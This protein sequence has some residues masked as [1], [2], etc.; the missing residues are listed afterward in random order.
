MRQEGFV[1]GGREREAPASAGGDGEA[2]EGL[3]R[4]LARRAA[5][6]ERSLPFRVAVAVAGGAVSVFAAL[7][8]LLT[9]ELGLPLL[10]FGLRTLALE[11]DWAARL[12]APVARLARKVARTLGRL[13]PRSKVG[14]AAVVLGLAGAFV[15]AFWFLA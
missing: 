6:R 15:A 8:S 1:A 14:L 5:H 3:A 10:L 2:A 12:Y 11:F 4:V 13:W 9:P 7:L